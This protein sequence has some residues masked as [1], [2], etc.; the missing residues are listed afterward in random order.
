MIR[1]LSRFDLE[2][3][4]RTIVTGSFTDATKSQPLNISD[5]RLSQSIIDV[6]L[7]KHEKRNGS[8]CLLLIAN[9]ILSRSRNISI[10]LSLVMSSASGHVHDLLLEALMV[11][12]SMVKGHSY[13]PIHRISV[14]QRNV[15]T[16][17]RF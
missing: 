15:Y 1:T 2:F 4:T 11:T 17:T 7:R 13:C 9:L 5:E 3:T 6:R 12:R 10:S 16:S 8:G 14:S